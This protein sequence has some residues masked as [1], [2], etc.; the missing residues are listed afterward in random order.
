MKKILIVVS[1]LIVLGSLAL[2]VL[3]VIAV[4]DN[5]VII[6]AKSTNSSPEHKYY[7]NGEQVGDSEGFCRTYRKGTW[8]IEVRQD[9]RTQAIRI[10]QLF[11]FRMDISKPTGDEL[12]L[13]VINANANQTLRQEYSCDF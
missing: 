5:P 1:S 9:N 10:Q 7:L 12:G 8:D 11:G 6:I 3:L 13:Q 2:F 4:K